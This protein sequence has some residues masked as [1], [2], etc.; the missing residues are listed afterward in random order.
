VKITD[1]LF[2]QIGCVPAALAIVLLCAIMGGQRGLWVG[3]CLVGGV[4]VFV[5]LLVPL[6]DWDVTRTE[7]LE[8]KWYLDNPRLD[9]FGVAKRYFDD[10]KNARWLERR[11]KKESANGTQG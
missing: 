1:I 10:P 9:P 5:G 4:L 2:V 3:L 6:I 8:K 11:R 7:R